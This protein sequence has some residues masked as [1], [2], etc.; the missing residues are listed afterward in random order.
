MRKYTFTIFTLNDTVY[1]YL[2]DKTRVEAQKIVKEI[3]AE[4]NEYHYY[5]EGYF[6]E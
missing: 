1:G 4:T 2:F 5:M 3:N 6:D